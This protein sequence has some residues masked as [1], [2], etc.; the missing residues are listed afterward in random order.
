[1]SQDKNFSAIVS[2]EEFDLSPKLRRHSRLPQYTVHEV[3]AAI[4]VFETLIRWRDEARE[5]GLID[6]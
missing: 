2:G 3:D 5:R 4:R 6:W 1:M